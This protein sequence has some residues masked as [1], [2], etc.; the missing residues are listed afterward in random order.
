MPTRIVATLWPKCVYRDK[1]RR[2]TLGPT[3][4]ASLANPAD[5]LRSLTEP[6][7]ATIVR[8]VSREL[9]HGGRTLESAKSPH[10]RRLAAG[11]RPGDGRLHAGGASA[12]DRPPEAP[13]GK[14]AEAAKPVAA[15]ASPAASP[16]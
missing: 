12:H 5:R 2:K 16:A 13:K 6:A 15:P 14:P 10:G 3:Q 4:T 1:L 7:G 11:R 9:G 8:P